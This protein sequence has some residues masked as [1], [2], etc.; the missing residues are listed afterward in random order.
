MLGLSREGVLFDRAFLVRSEPTSMR[1]EGKHKL[2]GWQYPHALTWKR[3]FYVAY[4]VNKEDVG[5]TRIPLR[6]L[7]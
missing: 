3:H 5:I 2:D 6:R 1:F 7:R 4:T